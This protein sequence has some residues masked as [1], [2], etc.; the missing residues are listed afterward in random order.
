MPTC[1]APL[2]ALIASRTPGTHFSSTYWTNSASTMLKMTRI[3]FAQPRKPPMTPNKTTKSQK[4]ADKLIMRAHPFPSL[5]G[6][7]KRPAP[8]PRDARLRV[9]PPPAPLRPSG[10]GVPGP[11]AARGLRHL[12]GPAGLRRSRGS[13][14]HVEPDN[15][16]SPSD[17]AT[18]TDTA[19]ELRAGQ[20]VDTR[21][22][23]RP[24][25]AT[26]PGRRRPTPFP[27]HADTGRHG[28]KRAKLRAARSAPAPSPP[29]RAGRSNESLGNPATTRAGPRTPPG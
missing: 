17:T 6:W 27:S 24:P 11:P 14:R 12:T 1:V 10:Q 26:R 7:L 23:P 20:R 2:C 16:R 29:S 21:R 5:Q 19:P 18:R 4:T 15:Q 25:P 3:S 28:N 9:A 22:A 8:G 13:P